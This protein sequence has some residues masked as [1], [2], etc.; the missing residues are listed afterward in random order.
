LY[1]R[2]LYGSSRIGVEDLSTTTVLGMQPLTAPT[3]TANAHYTNLIGDKAYELANHLGNVLNVVKDRKLATS[4][5][6]TTVAYFQPDVVSYSDYY[7]FGQ[8]LPYRNGNTPEY[9]Y[10][11]NNMEKDDE[12]KGNGNS[13]DFGDRIYDP[14]IGRWLSIDGF[15]KKF[16]W[17]TP[18]QFSGN[19][20]IWAKD[21]EGLE[22][23]K[24]VDPASQ[25]KIVIKEDDPYKST[26]TA[27]GWTLEEVLTTAQANSRINRQIKK[28]P[29]TWTL[30]TDEFGKNAT[31]VNTQ[32]EIRLKVD[33]AED[34]SEAVLG[35]SWE[36]INALNRTKLDE[37]EGKAAAGTIT[38]EQYIDGVLKIEADA[39]INREIIMY[40]LGMIE[41]PEGMKFKDV[42]NYFEDNYADIVKDKVADMKKNG[43]N[44]LGQ[45]PEEAYGT[46]YD[47]MR[48]AYDAKKATESIPAEG[49][50]SVDAETGGST[51]PPSP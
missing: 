30:R 43:K 31:C 46:Q 21:L 13:Y 24:P 26:K 5:N 11:F 8:A 25:S 51:K 3:P 27:G 29:V 1:F 38:K 12:L 22:A 16:P 14:R 41:I 28:L 17:W 45:T 18:Y 40:S 6:G 48:K 4:T 7:P 33:A 42:V 44:G 50:G 2:N 20:P 37:I 36:V 32:N 9:R 10:G 23:D 19:T 47:E 39:N 15:T 34:I 35:I 49:S